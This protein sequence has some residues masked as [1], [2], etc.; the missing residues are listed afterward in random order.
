MQDKEWLCQSAKASVRRVRI[1]THVKKKITRGFVTNIMYFV[2]LITLVIVTVMVLF[3]TIAY[4]DKVPSIFGW[5]LFIVLD[6]TMDY[7]LK[8]GDLSFTHNVNSSKI[9]VDDVIAYRTNFNSV[10]LHRV[11]CIT[12][13]GTG[14][15]LFTLDTNIGE[16]LSDKY[17]FEDRVEGIL[18]ARVP[19]VGIILLFYQRPVVTIIVILIIIAI[20]ILSYYIWDKLDERDRGG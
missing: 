9:N 15:R 20:G 11:L 17:V 16:S 13:L 14:Q 5:K 6:D 4:P 8:Y 2:V 10:M 7:S 18:K 12:E 1:R 3:Q 19:K